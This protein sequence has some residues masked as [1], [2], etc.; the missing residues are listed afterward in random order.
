MK[1]KSALLFFFIA[2]TIIGQEQ[3]NIIQ[4]SFVAKEIKHD[5][6]IPLRDMQIIPPGK[7]KWEKGVV[8]NKTDM[9]NNFEYNG[10][11]LAKQVNEPYR[12][13]TGT[14][15]NFDGIPNRNGVFPPDTQGDVG[16]D[17]YIQMIN[18]SFQIWDKEG[19]SLYGPANNNT[20]WNGFGDPWD[21][22]NDGDPVVLYDELADRWIFSQFALPNYPNGPF[23]ELIAVSET[24][25][26]LGAWYRYGFE[27]AHMPDYPK[28]AV[29]PDGYY[30]T[31]NQFTS[32]SLNW[33]GAG[34]AVLERDQMLV[35]GSA[36]MVFFNLGSSISSVLPSHVDG[37]APPVN[38]PNYLMYIGSSNSIKYYSLTVDWNNTANSQLTGPSTITV[39]GFN[40]S[41]SQDVAQPGTSQRL[42]ILE[43][44]LMF[45]LQYRNFGSYEAM[46]TNHTVNVG[47]NRAGLRWYEFRRT[48]SNWTLY[49]EGTF[50]PASDTHSRWM[51]SINMDGAGNIALGYSISSSTLHPSIRATGRIPSDPLGD[52]TV[53]EIEIR[54]GAG[55]QTGSDY[56]GRGRWG[57]Y[58]GMSVDPADDMTFWYTT[59]YM[60][61]TSYSG[62][63]TRIASFQISS[64]LTS[65][66]AVNNGWNI[67]SIPL[68]ADD[69]TVSTL[70]P[71]AASDAF[72]YN[73]AY[74]SV[75]EFSN[76]KG[77][78][79]KF[80]ADENFAVQ[81]LPLS[82]TIPVT[83]GW[84]IIGPFHQSVLVANIVSDLVGNIISDYFG[85]N[86]SYTSETSLEP[87]KGYW[88]K[89][90]AIGTLD[91]STVPKK[92][93]D[94]T[95]LPGNTLTSLIEI[96]IFASDRA[97]T[98]EI[99]LH[100]G[101]DP[102]AANSLDESL[103]ERELP[104]IAP[105]AFDAR[106]NLSSSS[107][108]FAS[109]R[110]YRTGG[111][112]F[113]GDQIHY[114]DY[115]L[116]SASK[117]LILNFTLPAGV[118]MNIQDAANGEIINQNFASGKGTFSNPA[119]S[120]LNQLKLT[121][122][123]DGSQQP[124]ELASFH[125][126]VVNDA[127]DLYWRTSTER[128]NLGFDIERS[129]DNYSFIKIGY[130]QASGSSEDM[131]SYS[132]KDESAINGKYYYRLKQLDTEG[133]Y[134]LSK[135]I[136]ANLDL[137]KDYE[138]TQ[139]YPNPFNPSTT[140]KF[141]LPVQ[142]RVT[143]KL[144]DIL[145]NEIKTLAEGFHIAGRHR[146]EF[147]SDGLASGVYIY[148]LTAVSMYGSK[149]TES[150]KMTLI[151]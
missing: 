89:A 113:K 78:W 145:G 13:N 21:G 82:T 86:G 66:F 100:G 8:P 65:N 123:Y 63:K 17:H 75:T 90:N 31:V 117:G 98:N 135:V 48:G 29:W 143:L 118:T 2:I 52:M 127:V 122:S 28:I 148:R 49:Q 130:I 33:R 128:N 41:F 11:D 149:F 105:N 37:D 23:Y 38:S 97:S 79:L 54:T 76:G 146:V 87:G 101:I 95:T 106:F 1:L 32:G 43:G 81:G 109:Y 19:N 134:S 133:N 93:V 74:N 129:E 10:E 120:A 18:L 119:T 60:Q 125:A 42:D 39:A 116:G 140:I 80:D 71:T 139:N 6:T 110:D 88:V 12:V 3:P 56:Y 36:D 26:P 77:Y 22:S 112:N 44:R 72:E 141:S 85:Y 96:A 124:V 137:P 102:S 9:P 35:G 7:S 107:F 126:S 50:A 144:Y 53:S 83:E 14:I 30:L 16:P 62:W 69:M 64:V 34:I 70:F 73:G 24:G 138:L 55:S 45:P 4:P 27:F 94:D 15:Q 51:G 108:N 46:V 103:G 59:E 92:P 104:P 115:D 25:D 150:K 61:T 58:S 57:D 5:K 91:I 84:N 67:I 47:T 68:D 20:L 99:T 40:S 136:E 114:L 147:N 151:K 131:N 121:L 111:N 142:S 132:F